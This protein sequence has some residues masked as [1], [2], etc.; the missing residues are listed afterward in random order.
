MEVSLGWKDARCEGMESESIKDEDIYGR[1]AKGI[2]MDQNGS[3][4]GY[5]EKWCEGR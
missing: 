5:C 4:E 3:F 1:I 2:G